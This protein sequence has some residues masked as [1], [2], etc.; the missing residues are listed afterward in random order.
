MRTRE[1]SFVKVRCE[2]CDVRILNNRPM[3]KCSICKSIKHFKCNGLSKNE[4]FEIIQNNPEWACQ[5]CIFCILPVN[6]VL[7]IKPKLDNCTACLKKISS[8]SFVSKCPWCNARC[9]KSCINGSLGCAEC[10]SD[11][12]PGSKCYAHELLG[13]TFL[14]SRPRFNPFCQEHHINQLGSRFNFHDEQSE[15][16][17]FSNQISQCE[18]SQMKNL[19]SHCNGSPR[20]LSLNIRSLFKGIEKLKDDVNILREKCDIIC[21]C[22]TNL[23]L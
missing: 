6:L 13:E 19:P 22:E 14:D 7:N 17:E 9:H 5:D 4:A 2:K 20:I 18:Y 1:G 15:W 21:L 23:K 3:L 16:N 10:C 8:N 11:I 12:I